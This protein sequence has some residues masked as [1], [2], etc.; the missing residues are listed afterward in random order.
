MIHKQK[1]LKVWVDIDIGI[2][3]MV[4]H[5]NT[6]KGVRTFASC[7]GT[8]G[9]GGPHPYPPDVMISASKKALKKVRKF[10][11]IGEKGNGWMYI[12]PFNNKENE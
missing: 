8:I 10:Y 12:H 2:Y 1:P 9:E 11:K 7:Q 3:K 4:K 5:L 6:I